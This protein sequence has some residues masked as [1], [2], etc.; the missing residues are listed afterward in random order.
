[1][2]RLYVTYGAILA[3]AAVFKSNVLATTT[4]SD[5]KGRLKIEITKKV[6]CERWTRKGDAL[7]VHYR[8]S[9]EASG[10][11]FETNFGGDPFRF[12]LGR[13]EVIEGWD[14]G[15]LHMCV[16]EHRKLTIPPGLAYGDHGTGDIPPNST[17]GEFNFIFIHYCNIQAISWLIDLHSFRNSA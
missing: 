13:G 14:K 15:L 17:L 12:R 5:E 10:E 11:E 16:G 3:I 9:L 6:S 2:V 4:K 1:M 7:E 8:G